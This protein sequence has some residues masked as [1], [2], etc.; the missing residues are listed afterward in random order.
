LWLVLAAAIIRENK[1]LS[2]VREHAA[3]GGS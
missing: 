3:P 1:K 2:E